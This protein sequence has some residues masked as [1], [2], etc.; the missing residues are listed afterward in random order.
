M[1]IDPIALTPPRSTHQTPPEEHVT[2]PSPSPPFFFL[3][4]LSS[5]APGHLRPRCCWLAGSALSPFCSPWGP[6]RWPA[7]PNSSGPGVRQGSYGMHL[8]L[9]VGDPKVTTELVNVDYRWVFWHDCARMH[10]SSDRVI[11]RW[12]WVL[13][14]E[15]TEFER[16]MCVR[17]GA[18]IN[19]ATSFSPYGTQWMWWLKGVY[20]QV[21]PG[22]AG[23]GSFK[24]KKNY[25]AKKEFAYRMCARWPTIAMPVL[26][27]YYSVL[28]ST[29]PVLLC[30]TSQYY[31]VLRGATRVT[32][33]LH[34]ILRLPRKM[35]VIND[36]RHIWKL[37]SNA[38]SK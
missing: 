30:T 21:V 1:S 8:L 16:L 10:S 31:S 27:Q 38:W 17:L 37:I 22:R 3:D 4:S 23:G 32:V 5:E 28:H 33:Q 29:T 19:F 13:C 15:Q 9:W 18:L 14:F 20:I 2:T 35:N 25:I 12:Y 26:L 24:R 11:S 34:Q 36:L 7:A 6:Q